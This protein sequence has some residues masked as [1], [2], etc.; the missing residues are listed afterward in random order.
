[1]EGDVVRLGKGPR[2]R[3]FHES[4][5][6][7]WRGISDKLVSVGGQQAKSCFFLTVREATSQ[8]ADAGCVQR[9]AE[10]IAHSARS[11]AAVRSGAYHQR[12]T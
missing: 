8:Y 9:R 10:M 4:Y 7:R 5:G 2:H 1:M 6:D 12:L 3:R 11:S